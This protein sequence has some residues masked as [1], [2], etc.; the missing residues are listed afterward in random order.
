MISNVFCVTRGLLWSSGK[1]CTELH[2]DLQGWACLSSED[3]AITLVN[4]TALYRT[5]QFTDVLTV[6]C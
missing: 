1:L 5:K 4:C 3:Q 2:R 6:D